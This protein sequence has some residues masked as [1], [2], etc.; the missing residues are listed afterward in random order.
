MSTVKVLRTLIGIT[1][2]ISNIYIYIKEHSGI[3]D[4][5]T[6]NIIA[7]IIITIYIYIRGY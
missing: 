1:I 6:V 2:W 7:L 5:L 4:Y 3:L